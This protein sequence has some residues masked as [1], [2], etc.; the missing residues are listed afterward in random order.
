MLL[1][2][3][4][5]TR[6]GWKSFGTERMEEEALFLGNLIACMKASWNQFFRQTKPDATNAFCE[7]FR[8]LLEK[9]HIGEKS[10]KM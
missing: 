4:P 1:A 7:D 2:Y 6:T 10:F 3:V 8:H 5:R 9:H